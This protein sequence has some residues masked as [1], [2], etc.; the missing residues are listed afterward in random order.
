MHA[1]EALGVRL[2]DLAH[3]LICNSG[4]LLCVPVPRNLHKAVHC[5]S[6]G[7]QSVQSGKRKAY[8]GLQSAFAIASQMEVFG[9]PQGH[10]CS[11][12]DDKLERMQALHMC[13][14]LRRRIKVSTTR[15]DQALPTPARGAHLPENQISTWGRSLTLMTSVSHCRYSFGRGPC[16]VSA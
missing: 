7:L 14:K 1:I 9:A 16:C 11:S 10:C 8:S 13:Q 15:G 2:P 3:G 5:R 12:E 6:F 4:Y